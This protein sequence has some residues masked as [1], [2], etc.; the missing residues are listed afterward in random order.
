MQVRR[1]AQVIGA[2]DVRSEFD[3]VGAVELGGV[4]D[5]L[6][7]ILFLIERAAAA[8]DELART[9]IE[10]LP[11]FFRA[12]AESA[13][14]VLNPRIDY[15]SREEAGTERIDIQSGHA[16][17]ARRVFSE[18]GR[19]HVDSVAEKAE[20]KIA[21]E[22][23][24]PRVIESVSDALVAALRLAAEGN[25]FR[26]AAFAE[27]RRPVEPEVGEAVAAKHIQPVAVLRVDANVVAVLVVFL[28]A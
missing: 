4:A 20:A 5:E 18:V 15:E 13:R 12:Q 11:Q 10:A 25:N 6:N 21:H 2:A 8:V 19:Q 7:L 28:A 1:D 3:R 17:V 24:I 26:P 9:E 16:H 14:D 22:P 27:G 23:V